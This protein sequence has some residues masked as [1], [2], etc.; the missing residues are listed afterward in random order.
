VN[1]FSLFAEP[2][3]AASTSETGAMALAAPKDTT[4]EVEETVMTEPKAEFTVPEKVAAMY[5]HGLADALSASEKMSAFVGLDYGAG[6]D[7]FNDAG[8]KIPDRNGLNKALFEAIVRSAKATGLASPGNYEISRHDFD[9]Y[10]KGLN[11]HDGY[12]TESK[13]KV[14]ILGLC[15][16]IYAAYGG[17]SGKRVEHNRVAKSLISAFSLDKAKIEVKSGM[18][19]LSQHSYLEKRYS[20]GYEISYS[21][22]TRVRDI[23]AN[24]KHVFSESGMHLSNRPLDVAMADYKFRPEPNKTVFT[25][26][27]DDDPFTVKVFKHELKWKFT[28]A[29]IA[30][31]SDFVVEYGPQD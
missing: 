17:D 22:Q 13:V 15:N 20:G 26:Q 16:A 8:H 4:K 3:K 12:D 18:V 21:S 5:Q 1:T 7:P 11:H 29:C 31:I 27:V 28:E 6:F 24:L 9:R 10:L 25:G 19:E 14:N 30:V 2:A 23:L